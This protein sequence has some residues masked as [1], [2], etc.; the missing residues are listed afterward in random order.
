VD[1]LFYCEHYRCTLRKEVCVK[2]QELERVKL[3]GGGEAI[4]FLGCR[5]C[6]QGK[7]IKEEML[8][9][10][11]KDVEEKTGVCEVCRW[12]VRHPIFTSRVVGECRRYAPLGGKFPQVT[13]EKWCGDFERRENED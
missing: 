13:G 3:K 8:V 5:N 9:K 6:E 4:E 7:E 12:F 2:R 10:K 1:D 11:K